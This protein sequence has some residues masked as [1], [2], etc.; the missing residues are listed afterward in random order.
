MIIHDEFGKDTFNEV[1]IIRTLFSNG[2]VAELTIS[3][4]ISVVNEQI[5]L[6]T[7]C[8]A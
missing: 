4:Y 3:V 6:F 8:S 7:E 5:N 1:E 2:N